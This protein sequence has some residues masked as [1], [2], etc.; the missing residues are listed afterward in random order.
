MNN[1]SPSS[2]RKADA[3]HRKADA[4][5]PRRLILAALGWL[6]IVSPASAQRPN[7]VW[8]LSEDNSKHYL[9]HF[10][11][12][13]AAAPNIEALA[14]QGI[15]FDRAFSN[16]P[17]CSVA[18]TTLI[19]ACY[20]PRIG[21]QFHRRNKPAHLSDGVQMF[22]AYLR[23]AGYYTTNNSKEDYN[24]VKSPD[25]WDESSRRASWKNR[26]T[27]NTPFF[28]VQTHTDSHESRLHF[29]AQAMLAPTQ[30]DPEQVKLQPYFPDTPTFR[31]TRA[32]YHDRMTVIDGLVGEMVND[33]REAGKLDETFIFYFGDHGGVLPGSKGYSKEA[34]LHVPLVVYVPAQFK[35]LVDRPVGSRSDGFVEFIDFGSTVLQLAGVP[36]P[37]RVDGRPFLG[38]GIEAAEVD[39]RDESVGY[40]DRFDE[41]YD[42]VRT[43]RKGNWKYVRNFEAFLPDGLQNNYRYRMLAFTEWRDLHR[44]GEL[45]EVQSQF[46]QPKPVE[47]LFDLESDPHETK[48]LAGEPEHA[49]RLA[50]LRTRLM[51][52]LQ[53]WPDLSL[54]P[55]AVLVAEAMDD[56]AAFGRAQAARIAK[57]IE[58]AN[59][60]LL[61]FEQAAGPLSESL[62]DADPW[63]RYWA[64][65]ACS[66]FG[67][68]AASLRLAVERLASD[69]QPLVAARV[70]EFLAILETDTDPRTL[71]Y[72]SILRAQSETEALQMLNTAVFLHDFSDGRYPI[73]VEQIRFG[74]KPREQ[75]E[76]LRRTDYLGGKL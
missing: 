59:L 16:S 52:R 14:E 1:C 4:D 24:A 23:A 8:I 31:F 53:G 19:T 51:Q 63:V 13:G 5:R 12:D 45:N 57:L 46:F 56:P 38:P 30:T 29:D 43:L 37:S 6:L 47:A 74:F 76:L 2:F 25:P 20:A 28:H 44:G 60:A 34:G 7:V 39:S 50:D 36:V 32:Y 58:T 27:S 10:D 3:S 40:A 70:A 17:V 65:I 61:P 75:S 15:T 26:P 72:E 62:R 68:Q 18:R 64:V 35:H 42:L 48:N 54:F 66:C 41:K 21:T 73:D 69:E 9:R 55:E 33:L 11:P 67:D 49:E 22:P 71:L